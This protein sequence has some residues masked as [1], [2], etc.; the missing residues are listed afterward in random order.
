MHTEKEAKRRK[1]VFLPLSTTQSEE[2]DGL[3]SATQTTCSG[4]P[5]CFVANRSHSPHLLKYWLFRFGMY[6]LTPN[7][8][9]VK[10]LPAN[11]GDT[12]DVG[13]IPGSGT[14]LRVGNG[15]PLQYSCL[16]NS[17][18]KGAW[19]VTVCGVPK[20]QSWLSIHTHSWLIIHLFVSGIQQSV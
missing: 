15:N 18:G 4:C 1:D 20:N 19:W 3:L 12:R 9:V 17:I 2:E 5:Y 8:S 13:L 14:S 6:H 10:N 7:N 16:E 11:A